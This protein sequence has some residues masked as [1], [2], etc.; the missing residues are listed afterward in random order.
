MLQRLTYAS[1]LEYKCKTSVLEFT[2]NLCGQTSRVARDRLDRESPTCAACGSNVRARSLIRALSLEIFGAN[3]ALPDF[4][5]V[6]SIRGLGI[7]DSPRYATR[8]AEVF[9]YRNTFYNREPRLDIIAPPEDQLGAYDFVVSSEVF[10]HVVAPVERA[11]E[12]AF[13]LLK[14]NG[15]LLLTVPY[16]FEPG[17]TEHFGKLYQFGL[18]QVGDRVLLV[19]R[20][21]EGKIEVHENLVFHFGSTGPVLEMR[22]F[23]ESALRSGLIAA[24]FG[25]VR[26]YVEND[27]AFGIVNAESWSLPIAARRGSFVFTRDAAG[28][29]LEQWAALRKRRRE[30][31]GS[32]W[33]RVAGKLGLVDLG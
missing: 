32:F 17:T 25:E 2:C 26:I 24:G 27:E 5:R 6:K 10:E 23:S 7:G 20:T 9:D 12:S 28:D 15:V 21:A 14:P 30:L 31:A 11:F 8:L 33:V 4:P 22:Q 1:T 18:A 13:R 3:L 16:T 29:V 19:N